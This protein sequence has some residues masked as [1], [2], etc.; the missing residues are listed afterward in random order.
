MINLI[1]MIIN[2]KNQNNQ[3]IQHTSAMFQKN[4]CSSVKSV[5]PKIPILVFNQIIIQI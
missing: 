3:L 1:K 2:Q 4:L 5:V